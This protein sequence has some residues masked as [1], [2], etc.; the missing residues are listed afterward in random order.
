VIF[1]SSA[2]R[3]TPNLT[4]PVRGVP[5]TDDELDRSKNTP[6]V[7]SVVVATIDIADLAGLSVTIYELIC[8]KI[9]RSLFHPSGGAIERI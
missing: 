5:L 8:I 4:S 2:W 9:D 6:E 7:T 3:L 1:A